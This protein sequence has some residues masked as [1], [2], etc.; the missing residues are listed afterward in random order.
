MPRTKFDPKKEQWV[1]G[2][3]P[4][5]GTPDKHLVYDIPC[6][7][8]CGWGHYRMIGRIYVHESKEDLLD[9]LDQAA[10]EQK[11]TSAR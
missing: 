10:K 9:W 11:E 4:E 8:L 1:D 7:E 5:T 6:A 2:V 3:D